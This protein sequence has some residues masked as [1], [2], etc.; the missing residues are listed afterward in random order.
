M[1]KLGGLY[2]E[3]PLT[4]AGFAVCALAISGV[5]PLNGFISKE[6]IFHGALETGYPIFAIAAWVGAIFTFA[7]FLK[8]GHAIFLGPRGT[9]VPPVKESEPPIWLPILGLAAFCILFGVGNTLPVNAFLQPLVGAHFPAEE[10]PNLT[11]HALDLLSPVALVSLGMLALGFLF[12]LTGW[13]RAQK[14][15][16]MAS[17]IIHRL[18]VMSTLYGWSEA[19]YF[20]LYEYGVRLVNGSSTLVFRFVDR[21]IDAFYETVLVGAGRLVVRFGRWIHNGLYPNYLAWCL[22]GLAV[23][24]LLLRVF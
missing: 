21:P 24:L 14:K 9:D 11:E 2:R 15:A 20:D 4:A 7:S 17:E 6:M 13:L 8:A 5:W 3:M 1:K 23:I 16:Y 12:H 18:P 10:V 22:A 19:R